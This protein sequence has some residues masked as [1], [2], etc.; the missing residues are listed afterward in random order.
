MI[1]ENRL[2][3][4]LAPFQPS[5]LDWHS[6]PGN[7][8]TSVAKR[9]IRLDVPVD[10]FPNVKCNNFSF[11]DLFYFFYF[12]ITWHPILKSSS[13]ILLAEFWGHVETP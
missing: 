10:K 11:K 2:L 12:P 1:Q 13:I 9:V 4:K 6:A 3:Q 8:T 5:P 7:S